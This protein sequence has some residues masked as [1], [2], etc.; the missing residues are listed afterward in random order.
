[1]L[2]RLA[3]AS[4]LSYL[5]LEKMRLSP[6]FQ[7]SQLDPLVQVVDPISESGATIFVEN[8]RV[9]VACR[10][11]ANPKN[12]VTNL[13]F[14]LVPATLPVQEL[15]VDSLVHEGFQQASQGLWQQLEPKLMDILSSQ[16]TYQ[17]ITFTGHSLGGATALL[18]SVH[19]MAS[20]LEQQPASP[21]I[22]TFAGPRLCN[23]VLARHLRQSV[24]SDCDILHLAHDKDPVLAN[25][26]VLWDTLDFEHVGVELQCDPNTPNVYYD[27]IEQQG[28]TV[29]GGVA[30][31]IVDH[32]N[33]LGIFVG[34]RIL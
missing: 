29:L 4:S 1:S 24:L 16:N 34:P 7:S 9:V 22:V 5:S 18:C 19:Y 30:W 26:K 32:C 20:A 23:S 15:P 25:N 2:Q 31:N 13:R 12:F 6:Y 3:K 28:S 27:E 11:S 10:G 33:Y 17:E 14:K 8:N 21:S